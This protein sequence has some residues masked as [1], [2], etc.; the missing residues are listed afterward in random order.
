MPIQTLENSSG[1]SSP[2]LLL[3]TFKNSADQTA[4]IAQIKSLLQNTDPRLGVFQLN[5]IVEKDTSFLAS[6]WQ[7]IMI[8]PFFAL[9]ASA[10]CTVSYMMLAADEQRQ[11]LG[12]LRAVGA[13]PRFI[14][15]VLALQSAVLLL[16]SFGIGISLGTIITML[17]LIQQPIV[18]SFTIL[19]IAGLL[20]VALAGIL[21]LSLYPAFKLARAS[22]LKIIT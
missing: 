10:L 21:L 19:E 5:S 2:N 22:I 7:T 12:V 6:N 11:E 8:M 9:A 4:A 20:F 18:T 15:S 3:V 17:I 14:V 1:I 16:S 13:K